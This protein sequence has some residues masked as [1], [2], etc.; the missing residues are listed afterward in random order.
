M[1][2]TAGEVFLPEVEGTV[3]DAA[4]RVPLQPEK[5][6]MLETPYRRFLK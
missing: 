2:L 3:T 4:V 5:F 1:T 6:V